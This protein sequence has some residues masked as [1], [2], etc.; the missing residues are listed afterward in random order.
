MRRWRS[1]GIGR[2]RIKPPRPGLDWRGAYFKK[3]PSGGTDMV[4]ISFNDPEVNSTDVA[5]LDRAAAR[6][7]RQLQRA[8]GPKRRRRLA[9]KLGSLIERREV[10]A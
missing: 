8:K 10:A 9:Q 5:R 2:R 1:E 7:A 4:K 6:I 3:H